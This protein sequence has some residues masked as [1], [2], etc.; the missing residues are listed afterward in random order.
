MEISFLYLRCKIEGY[1]AA[2]CSPASGGIP[3]KEFNQSIIRSLTPQQAAGNALA[4]AVQISK[5][6][7][8]LYM[9][10]RQHAHLGQPKLITFLCGICSQASS[11]IEI[12]R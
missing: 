7:S 8:R 3:R 9:S 10:R 6:L 5:R 2:S 11:P 1:P 12:D 4:I